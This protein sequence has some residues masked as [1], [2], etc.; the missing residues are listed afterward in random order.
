MIWQPSLPKMFDSEHP[1]VLLCRVCGNGS[2]NRRFILREMRFG[3]RE[4]FEYSQC[5]ACQSIQI[6]SSPQDLSKYYRREYHS[7]RLDR[8]H[9]F[10]ALNRIRRAVELRAFVQPNF[11]LR[12][13]WHSL[14]ERCE[15]NDLALEAVARVRPPRAARILDVGCGPGTLLRHLYSLGYANLLGVDP[16]LPS[17]AVAGGVQLLST[18]IDKL[19]AALRFDVI[20]LYH[21][22]EHVAD[23]ITTLREVR[24]HLTEGGTV[25]VA[26]PLVGQP[27]REFGPNWY[28]LDPPYHY[29]V[30]SLGGF[31]RIVQSAGLVETARYFNSTSVQFR[32]SEQYSRGVPLMS[33]QR[34]LL[35]SRY[36]RFL[37]YLLSPRGA[38]YRRRSHLLN[39]NETGDQAVF[40]LR[41]DIASDR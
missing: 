15:L 4:P 30:F 1:A 38:R 9:S 21:S 22:I 5:S 29:Y 6:L 12:G 16:F 11:G 36:V 26:T 33:F 25:I 10:P 40:Y 41:R 13:R 2:G 20:V 31:E 19:D 34:E 28:A 39:V 24:T 3:T 7:D 27:F 18:T 32:I 17:D 14:L 8:V 23:P 37:L 35:P